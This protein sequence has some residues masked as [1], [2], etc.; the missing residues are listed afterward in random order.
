MRSFVRHENP[1]ITGLL[2]SGETLRKPRRVVV[3]RDPFRHLRFGQT[4]QR[5]QSFHGST[6]SPIPSQHVFV[7]VSPSRSSISLIS[8]FTVSPL[9]RL[10]RVRRR[11][12]PQHPLGPLDRLVFGPDPDHP[13]LSP[14]LAQRIPKRPMRGPP[15][16]QFTIRLVPRIDVGEGDGFSIH[17]QGKLER[18]VAFPGSHGAV[19]DPA[20]E[21]AAASR[22]SPSKNST[23]SGSAGS[24]FMP[25]CSRTKSSDRSRRITTGGRAFRRWRMFSTPSAR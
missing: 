14:F 8:C 1:S 24:Q 9:A 10:S 6:E 20:R 3:D 15:G 2:R 19:I 7:I 17:G 18:K 21:S 16:V 22:P 11:P 4:L 23:F 25:G 5:R 12:S 13:D